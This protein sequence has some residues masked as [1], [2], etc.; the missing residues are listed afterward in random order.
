M[1]LAAG[2]FAGDLVAVAGFLTNG[3][4]RIIMSC[5]P[6][7]TLIWKTCKPVG[8]EISCLARPGRRPK[9]G[10]DCALNS[11]RRQDNPLVVALREKAKIASYELRNYV[12]MLRIADF[13]DAQADRMRVRRGKSMPRG[14]R[15]SDLYERALEH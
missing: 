12:N 4:L 10:T 7:C 13:R 1:V 11:G 9:S 8:I 6:I 15:P 3:I 5:K 14:K 2:F